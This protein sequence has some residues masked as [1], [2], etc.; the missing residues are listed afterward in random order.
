MSK[1]SL[2][3]KGRNAVTVSSKKDDE[4]EI[5]NANKSVDVMVSPESKKSWKKIFKKSDKTSNTTHH[6]KNLKPKTK[7]LPK[8][9]TVS[10]SRIENS[11]TKENKA[12]KEMESSNCRPLTKMDS[13]ETTDQSTTDLTFE[14]PSIS[15]TTAE[16]DAVSLHLNKTSNKHDQC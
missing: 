3:R 1:K 14:T 5:D 15:S 10:T 9:T 4:N 11:L 16:S 2:R 12:R 6:Q 8:S 7:P 13:V